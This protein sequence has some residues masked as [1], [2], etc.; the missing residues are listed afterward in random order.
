G[1]D[2]Q[3]PGMR[4]AGAP[5]VLTQG[6]GHVSRIRNEQPEQDGSAPRDRGQDDQQNA[7]EPSR[8]PTHRSS[9]RAEGAPGSQTCKRRALPAPADLVAGFTLASSEVERIA[10]RE[11][12]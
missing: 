9:L 6:I 8:F 12:A 4:V 3:D 5:E 10:R 1:E 11:V 7:G 2:E